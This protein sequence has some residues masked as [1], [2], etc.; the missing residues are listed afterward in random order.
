MSLHTLFHTGQGRPVRRPVRHLS[1]RRLLMEG[2]EDRKL[3]AFNVVAEYVTGSNPSDVALALIDS[4]SQADLVIAD[5]S[6][7]QGSVRIGNGDGTFGTAQSTGVAA[8]SV[9]TG[10]VNSDG[11]TDLVSIEAS[12]IIQNGNGNGTF[13]APQSIAL[14]P[15]VAPGNTDPTPLPQK[16]TSIVSGDLNADG[17][18][19][20]VVSGH[21]E[22]QEYTSYLLCGYYGCSYIGFWS[23]LTDGYVNVLIGNGSGGFSV[24]TVSSLGRDRSPNSTAI[25]DL[26]NDGKADVIV[27]NQYELSALPGDGA[28]SL[29]TPIRSGNGSSQQSISLGDFDGDGK[30]DALTGW[31]NSMTLQKG[32]GNG[33]FAP[34]LDIP[35]PHAIDSA[36]VGDVNGDGELDIAVAGNAYTCTSSGYYGCYDGYYR[37]LVNVVLGNGVGNFALPIASSLGTE[38]NADFV[39]LALAELNGDGRPDLVA[40]V[41]VTG[42]A[43]VT[44]NDGGWIPPV[45][46]SISDATIVEGHSGSVDVVFNISLAAPSSQSVTVDYFTDSSVDHWG[47]V[48]TQGVDYTATA[49]TITIPAGQTSAM[50]NVPIHGDRIGEPDEMFL[51][52]LSNSTNAILANNQALGLILDD[53]P[54]VSFEYYTGSEV[55]EGNSGTKPM[56]FIVELSGPSDIPV[57]VDFAT[58][59]ASALAGVDYQTRTGK[60]TFAPGVTTQ[61]IVVQV[62][63]DTQAETDEYFQVDL[64]KP[65]NAKIGT[66]YKY[67]YI[68]DND[69]V[70]ALS[71]SDAAVY[72]GNSGSKLMTFTITLSQSVSTN[73]SVNY[74]TANGT[75]KTTDND[76]LSKSGTVKFKPGEWTKTVTVTV[77]GDKK[78]EADEWFYVNLS[79]AKGVQLDDSQGLGTILNDDGR[80]FAGLESSRA[81]PLDLLLGE[82]VDERTKK[83]VR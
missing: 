42:R 36:L 25:G 19:D 47:P 40:I 37:G 4:G 68:I 77:K 18:L 17:K 73:V 12:V 60:L 9:I 33:T 69:T 30:L 55:T 1:A 21:T 31:S 53:E 39:D 15:Q 5:N 54:Y 58:L 70:P 14:P 74:W 51:V 6:A 76:Y 57:T 20:L 75:A 13:Q 82:F 80:N 43:F 34:S 41:K 24:P 38:F 35:I 44:T 10:D 83:R 2:L 67:G 65:I 66:G 72:E 56:T 7:S 52:S 22:F 63:G 11:I 28:G 8:S 61:T 26:N 32:H 29:A 71:I 23:T 49:G 16:L 81:V 50:I 59:D 27:T 46:L 78:F 64:Y 48:A 62:I 3:M 45:L 79:H